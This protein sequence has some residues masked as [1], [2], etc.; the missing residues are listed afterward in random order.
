MEYIFSEQTGNAEKKGGGHVT[1]LLHERIKETILKAIWKLKSLSNPLRT[2]SEDTSLTIPLKSN[3]KALQCVRRSGSFTVEAAFVLPL[4]LFAALVVLGIFPVLLLQIQV[5]HGLQYAARLTAVSYQDQTEEG[6]I[7]SMAEG[8][9]LF[10]RYLREHGCED[11]VLSGGVSGISLLHSDFSGDY[12]YLVADYEAE[13][14]ISFWGIDTLPVEQ[15]VRMKKWT[16]ADPETS[17]GEDGY[18][19]ITPSG[20]AYHSTAECPYLKLS[21]QSV[22]TSGVS[23]MRNKDGGIYYPCSCYQG[24]SRVYITDYGTQYHGDLKCSGL[25]RTIYRV[26]KEQAEDRHACARCCS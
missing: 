12:V 14:P 26:P 24:Q 9:L 13:L 19:Y 3:A 7:L 16:G 6:N 21:I 11:S 22:P 20:S 1:V 17:A 15:C 25:K 5:N 2:L 4:F 23:Q 8:Q 18:V 10:R